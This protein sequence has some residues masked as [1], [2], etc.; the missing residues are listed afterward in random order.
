LPEPKK[1]PLPDVTK[2]KPIKAYSADPYMALLLQ[3]VGPIGGGDLKYKYVLNVIDKRN[4]NPTCLVTL[5]NSPKS[6]VLC[7]FEDGSLSYF[8]LLDGPD[9][10]QEFIARSKAIVMK[11]FNL[12]EMTELK[13]ES[14]RSYPISQPSNDEL[15][16]RFKSIIAEFIKR[17]GFAE[18]ASN[19]FHVVIDEEYR[20]SISA[21]NSS[22]KALLSIPLSDLPL[23]DLGLDDLEQCPVGG[24]VWNSAVSSA[25][26]YVLRRLKRPPDY[27]LRS[28]VVQTIDKFIN[29]H[30]LAEFTLTSYGFHVVI[31]EEYRVSIG[32][33]MFNKMG[34]HVFAPL[35]E[36]NLALEA[37]Q[38]GGA[39]RQ[40][41]IDMAAQSAIERLP[42]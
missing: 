34:E 14:D 12:N 39:V 28:K 26:E 9:L 32:S 17:E 6:N 24:V 4:N 23:R 36:L 2:S 18:F 29:A 33:I 10:M 13:Q 35:R 11:R 21:P 41:A 5:E 1:P 40:K 22:K 38:E 7:V 31:D 19:R 16:A 30:G 25:A 3:D 37:V 42:S 15:E 8:E 27:F 20:A